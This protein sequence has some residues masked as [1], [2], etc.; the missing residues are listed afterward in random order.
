MFLLIIIKLYS[1]VIIEMKK[2]SFA[3]LVKQKKKYYVFFLEVKK[4]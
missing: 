2:T 4:Q 1:N 3:A